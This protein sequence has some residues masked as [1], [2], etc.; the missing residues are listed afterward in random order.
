[1]R[2]MREGRGAAAV[3]IGENI[4]PNPEKVDALLRDMLDLAIANGDQDT[5]AIVARALAERHTRALP[6]PTPLAARL[7]SLVGRVRDIFS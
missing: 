2:Y 6:P 4:P 1:M 7:E 3:W 5:A